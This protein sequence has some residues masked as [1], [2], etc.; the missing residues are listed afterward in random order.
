MHT[1]NL[2][3]K[4]E[5]IEEWQCPECGRHMLVTWNPKFK[6]TVLEAGD[7][8]VGHNG[9]KNNLRPENMKDKLVDGDSSN[10]EL[11]E[12]I[13]EERL[14]PWASWMKKSNYSKR[15]NSDIQ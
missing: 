8:S 2:I 3:K 7:L 14:A 5:G 6:R 9:F 4:H 10:A 13:D 12:P 1:M 11:N 15:W